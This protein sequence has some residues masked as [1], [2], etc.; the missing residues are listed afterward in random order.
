[1]R[2]GHSSATAGRTNIQDAIKVLFQ[3]GQVVE[4]RVPKAGKHGTIS[5]YFDDHSK[6][7][8]ELENLSGKVEAV[9]YTLNPVNP[10]LLARSNNRVKPYA[11]CLTSDQPDNIVGRRW[12]LVDCDPARPSEIPSTAGEKAVARD[13]AKRVRDC[14][15]SLG[16]PGPVVADSGNGYHLLYRI[17]LP[18]D[19]EGRSLPGISAQGAGREIR[20]QRRE[21]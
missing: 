6:L 10:A 9:Y 17:D 15:K 20:H 16:W 21:D 7:A 5:G 14:L 3:A 4:L 2:E 12:L 11:K 18:N 8:V 1:M 13:T 19:G